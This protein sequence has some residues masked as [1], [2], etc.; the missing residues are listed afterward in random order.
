MVATKITRPD[1]GPISDEGAYTRPIERSLRA[2]HWRQ[3]CDAG[4]SPR[5]AAIALRRIERAARQ[6]VADGPFNVEM[7]AKRR[8]QLHAFAEALSKLEKA[9]R[10]QSMEAML[11]LELRLAEHPE[12]AA[13]QAARII[14]QA[15][16]HL[17]ELA[18]MARDEAAAVE[19]CRGRQRNEM[20]HLLWRTAI[21]AWRDAVGALPPVPITEGEIQPPHLVW[22]VRNTVNGLTADSGREG[23]FSRQ[24]QRARSD[25]ALQGAIS[26]DHIF[27]SALDGLCA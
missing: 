7:D 12:S 21:E 15:A 3:L 18:A 11:G 17:G 24:V 6:Y 27:R 2:G 14:W 22:I 26:G 8:R 9:L 1:L 5:D 23:P 19:V 16:P 4:A 13:G 20:A 25:E 10:G